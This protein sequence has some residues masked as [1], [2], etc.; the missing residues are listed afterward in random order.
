MGSLGGER[1]ASRERGRDST[2]RS[3]SGSR[4]GGGGGRERGGGAGVLNSDN[5]GK[6]YW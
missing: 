4:R 1:G 2:V 5:N 6:I 3:G